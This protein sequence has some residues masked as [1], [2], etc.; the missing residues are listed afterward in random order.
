M[1]KP[2]P[3]ITTESSEYWDSCRKG[4]LIYQHCLSCDVVQFYPRSQCKQCGSKNLEYRESKGKGTIRTFT[5][6]HRAPSPAFKE[7]VPYILA[8]ID[9]DEGF[10]MMSNIV[11]TERDVKIGDRVIIDFEKRSEDIVIPQFKLMLTF[12]RLKLGK[13]YGQEEFECSVEKVNQWQEIYT[14]GTVE[15][16][17]YRTVPAGMCGVIIMNTYDTSLFGRPPGNVH[18]SQTF[19][20]HKPIHVGDTVI[21][22]LLIEDK[23]MMNDRKWVTIKTETHS[24]DGTLLIEGR[25]KILWAE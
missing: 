15:Q 8:L 18:G 1:Q 5:H 3:Y 6:V 19:Q 22:K 17:V 24:A 2:L 20:Y 9:L 10:R 7:D 14:D 21:T 25:M 16:K 13:I 11:G 12:D 23:I 4:K